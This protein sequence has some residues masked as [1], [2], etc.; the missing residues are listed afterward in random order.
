MV[1]IGIWRCDTKI[2]FKENLYTV[3]KMFVVENQSVFFHFGCGSPWCEFICL[4]LLHRIAVGALLYCFTTSFGKY[5]RQLKTVWKMAVFFRFERAFVNRPASCPQSICS[6]AFL[7]HQVIVPDAD[8][9]SSASADSLWAARSW[10][11]FGTFPRL[12]YISRVFRYCIQTLSKQ[13]YGKR[14]HSFFS[15]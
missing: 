5:Y 2:W 8:E 15:T 6:T 7:L 11:C 10:I 3:S 14:H 1:L 4:Q 9:G 12:I 13:W